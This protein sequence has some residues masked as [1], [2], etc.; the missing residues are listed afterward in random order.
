MMR[1]LH[2]EKLGALVASVTFSLI[3]NTNMMLFIRHIF[4]QL[5]G[6]MIHCT[7]W[8]FEAFLE[9]S[10]VKDIVHFA[11]FLRKF[12]TVGIFSTS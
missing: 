7:I 1:P 10:H 6:F 3:E 5:D 9:L 11:E 12:K 4:L 2:F 8:V